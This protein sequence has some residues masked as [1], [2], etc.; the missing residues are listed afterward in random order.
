MQQTVELLAKKFGIELIVSLD[1][2]EE[3]CP[4]ERNG[5]FL[6]CEVNTKGVDEDCPPIICIYEDGTAQFWHDATPYPV[7][8]N[9]KAQAREMMMFLNP[10]PVAVDLITVEDFKTF[11]DQILDEESDEDE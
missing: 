6:Q 7:A 9:T 5:H 10:F 4:D 2:R 8:A 3:N 1:S 11:M